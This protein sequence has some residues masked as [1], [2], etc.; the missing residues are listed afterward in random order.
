[1]SHPR[2]LGFDL[3]MRDGVDPALSHLPGAAGRLVGTPP[4]PG[5]EHEVR[6][7]DGLQIERNIAV[8]L[9]DGVRILID[10]YRPEGRAGEQ[11]LAALLGWSPYGKHN[12]SNRLWPPADVREGWISKYTAFEA[13]DP[14][15]WCRHGYAVIYPD[16]RGTWYSEGEMR[17]G[18]VGEGE[19][20]YDL[21]EWVGTQPWSNG[22]VGM[23]GVSYLTT[24]Q[25]Q[26]AP[27]KPPH[28]AAINPWEGFSDW[29]REFG[30]HGGMRDTGFIPRSAQRL[31]WSTTRTED[32]PANMLA[33]PLYDAY[34]KSKEYDLA[35]IEV[36][37]FVVASWSDQGL[38]TR[39]TLEAFK[40]MSSKEKWLEVHGQKKWHYYYRPDCVEKQRKFFDHFLKDA[41]NSVLSWPRVNIEV[42]ERA[43]AG[44][45]RAEREWPLARTQFRKLFLDANAAAM[46]PVPAQAE[47]SVRYDPLDPEGKA[48]FD[49]ILP[50]DTEMTGH[51]KLRL[52][53][54]AEGAHDMDLFV[55]IQK[56]DAGGE[57]VPFVFYAISDNGPVALGWLRASHRELDEARS[58]P[59]QPVHLHTREQPLTPGVPVP[60]EIEIWPSSTLFRKGERLRVLIQGRDIYTDIPEGPATF[61]HEDLRNEGT[62]ILRTGGRFDSHLLVPIIPAS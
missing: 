23:S 5:P 20:C 17:H 24:I 51:M 6:S 46:S 12:L 9:R 34:W 39:G 4:H 7:A 53:A 14:L 31:R 60:L 55:A 59:E 44:S 26:V 18:G 30:Y 57:L 13:P 37:A 56:S 49:Y 29:Y 45:F 33:H 35:G 42:R 8:T 28:L 25:Y 41:D 48:V 15:Y 16:P 27:L 50:E 54:E 3:I 32:T 62:H 52:W 38:H 47:S 1:M 2:D 21:I 22:K 61:R 40:K 43:Y 58:K 11:G 19:D 10:L 36:P